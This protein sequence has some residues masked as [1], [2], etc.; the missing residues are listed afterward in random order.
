[1]HDSDTKFNTWDLKITPANGDF[2]SI[3][4]SGWTGPRKPDGSLPDIPFLKLK[5]GSKL[6]DKGTDVGFPF[7]GAAPDLGA[8]EFGAVTGANM[9]PEAP[10]AIPVRRNRIPV[11]QLFDL[12]GRRIIPGV[13]GNGLR[14]LIYK[15]ADGELRPFLHSG[16]GVYPSSSH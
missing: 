11:L 5:S 8:Y 1:M 3:S 4:D 7:T 14:L 16:A 9:R 13:G 15:T 2:E 12:A 10:K 6:I